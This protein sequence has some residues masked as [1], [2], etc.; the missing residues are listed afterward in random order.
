MKKLLVVAGAVTLAGAL[1]ACATQPHTQASMTEGA[2]VMG[3]KSMMG[4]AAMPSHSLNCTPEALASM[5]PEHRQA[6]EKQP[7]SQAQ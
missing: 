3:P 7:S 1:S 5:P 6:C 2:H 4:D